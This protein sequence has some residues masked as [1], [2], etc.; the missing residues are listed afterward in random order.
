MSVPVPTHELGLR[1]LLSL[2]LLSVRL[3]VELLLLLVSVCL[4]AFRPTALKSLLL[5]CLLILIELL[6]KLSLQ[7]GVLLH[8]YVPVGLLDL[9]EGLECFLVVR[10]QVWV[11]LLGK[12][13]VLLL[14]FG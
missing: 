6:L 4:L 5:I 7:L 3:V 11:I 12:L 9:L 13:E 2:L 10:V 8:L 14:D 1:P